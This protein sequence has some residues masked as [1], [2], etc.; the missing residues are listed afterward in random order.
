MNLVDYVVIGL[1]AVSLL[2]GL[3]R[4]F[5]SSVLN[6]AATLASFGLSFVLYPRLAELIQSNAELKNTFLT[7]TDAFSRIGDQTLAYTNVADLTGETIS[8]IV[9]RIQLPTPLDSLV[10]KALEGQIYNG[11]STVNDYVSQTILTACINIVCYIVCFVVLA[12]AFAVI[13]NLLKTV[14]RF[15]V[16]KQLD[17]LA[18]GVFGILRGVLICFVLFTVAPLVLTVVPVDAVS[19]LIN[20]S[21]LAPFFTN[22]TLVTAIM[23]GRLGL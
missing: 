22:G 18:G 13:V 21:T 12:L 6:T 15:P 14:F 17:A 2:F 3:Y 20:E 19:D 23:N 16:L 9:A 5:L 1:I 11:I 8:D 10:Q 7:Y 4:G